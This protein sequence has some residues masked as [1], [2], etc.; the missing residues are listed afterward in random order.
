MVGEACLWGYASFFMMESWSI[1]MAGACLFLKYGTDF[2]GAISFV[3]CI[4]V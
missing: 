1:G 4:F 3:N 2:A